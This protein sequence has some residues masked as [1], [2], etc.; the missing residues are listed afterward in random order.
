MP[1]LLAGHTPVASLLH[2]DLWN[3]NA[4]LDETGRLALYDPA[5]YYGDRETD[6]AMMDLFGGFPEAF[7]A[8][9]AEAWPLEAGHEMRRRLYQLYH[10]LNHANLFGG[11][12]AGQALRMI[13]KLLAE[14]KS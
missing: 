8:A 6:L 10:V 4:A 13:E 1:A 2:G 14:I 5:V 3:G 12:Y 7:V 9:Y 11:S